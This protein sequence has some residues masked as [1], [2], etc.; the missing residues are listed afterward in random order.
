MARR[1]PS[2]PEP[3]RPRRKTGYYQKFTDKPTAGPEP[4]SSSS[5]YDSPQGKD[6]GPPQGADGSTDRLHGAGPEEPGRLRFHRDGWRGPEI[7]PTAASRPAPGIRNALPPTGRATLPGSILR[8]T[9]CPRRT[10][11]RL[12]PGQNRRRRRTA[13]PGRPT[14]NRPG[15]EAPASRRRL[16]APRGG[17]TDTATG[18]KRPTT[19]C[20]PAAV[21]AFPRSATPKP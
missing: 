6:A 4:D 2:G 12:G 10:R 5:R 3:G 20:P 14:G 1:E 21:C 13:P 17:P 7:R 18:S 9:S 8:R 11:E 19:I 16:T 15:A